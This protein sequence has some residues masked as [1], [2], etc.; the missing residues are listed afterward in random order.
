M[1]KV[2]RLCLLSFHGYFVPLSMAT[3]KIAVDAFQHADYVQSSSFTFS[4]RHYPVILA[5]YAG[6]AIEQYN[7]DSVDFYILRAP[8]LQ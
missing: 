1:L 7:T 6:L 3:P 4:N 8:H 2:L 5:K